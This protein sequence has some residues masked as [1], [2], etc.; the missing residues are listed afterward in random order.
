MHEGNH[1]VN[2][3]AATISQSSEVMSF[4]QIVPVSIQSGSNKLNAYA[5]L[6]IAVIHG[7]KDLKTKIVS[8]KIKGPHSNVHLIKAFVHPSISLGTTH[9]DYNNLKQSFSHL[10]FLPNKTFNLMDVGINLG[11][12]A[13]ELQSKNTK[14]TIRRSNRI[15]MGSQWI[16]DR[17]EKTKHLSFRLHR[18]CES[19]WEYPK[20][21]GHRNLCFQ[22]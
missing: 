19:G 22:S 14:W 10:N 1:A 18:R 11:Q 7:T 4:L 2:M 17:Q 6:E 20:M 21:V 5:F 9:Y 16:H 8:I 3:S 13:Y 15:R 12:D